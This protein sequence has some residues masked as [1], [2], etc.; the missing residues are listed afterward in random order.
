MPPFNDL[1]HENKPVIATMQVVLATL[2]VATLLGYRG[3]LWSAAIAYTV[4]M[5]SHL[6]EWWIPHSTG[7]RPFA[8]KLSALAMAGPVAAIAG[9]GR[10]RRRNMTRR[11][12]RDR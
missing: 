11:S 6:V 9:C 4:V 5:V 2:G 1:R 8:V 10:R 3:A 12:A 7:W